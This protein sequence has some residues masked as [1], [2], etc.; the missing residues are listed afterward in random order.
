MTILTLTTPV[1]SI[2]DRAFTEFVDRVGEDIRKTAKTG[3]VIKKFS[4]SMMQPIFSFQK[5]CLQMQTRGPVSSTHFCHHATAPA[6]IFVDEF[7]DKI[8]SSL[9]GDYG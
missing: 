1:R 3:N 4:P 6:H 9:Y 5:G 8:L 7:N 2:G